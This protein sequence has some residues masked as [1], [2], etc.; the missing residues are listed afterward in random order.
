MLD[1]WLSRGDGHEAG[2]GILSLSLERGS[3]L[4]TLVLTL[5]P[6][7]TWDSHKGSHQSQVVASTTMNIIKKTNTELV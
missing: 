6:S 4:L 7:M 2:A 3:F 5:P 1:L